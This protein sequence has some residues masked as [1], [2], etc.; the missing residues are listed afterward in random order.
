[1][2]ERDHTPNLGALLEALVNAVSHPRGKALAFLARARVTVD[3][4]ILLD[5]ARR[6]GST[7]SSL[8]A[9]MG[10][11]PSSVSQMIDRLVAGEYVRRVDDAR[12]RRR[13]IV[14][15]TRKARAFL[16]RFGAV[17]RDELATGAAAL[18]AATRKRLASAIAEALREL[19]KEVA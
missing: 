2:N 5:R 3:Q 17:R 7:P 8:A 16:E 13:K 14:E 6:S 10:L 15:P 18:S 4:A 9:E 11:S 19:G 1:M 12:D